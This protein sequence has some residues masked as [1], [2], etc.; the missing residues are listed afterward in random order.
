MRIHTPLLALC[1]A[2][3]LPACT[4]SSSPSTPEAPTDISITTGAAPALIAVR[5]ES[6]GAWRRLVADSDG[7]F[8]ATVSGP[9]R[10]VVVCETPGVPRSISATEYARTSEDEPAIQHL[11]HDAPPYRLHGRMLSP[12]TV[13]FGRVS[14]SD[15]TDIAGFSLPASPGAF[16]LVMHQRSGPREP[17]QIAIRRDVEISG[18]TDLGLIDLRSEHVDTMT[19]Q[20]LETSSIQPNE[21][22][23]SSTLLHTGTT[24]A[25]LDEQPGWRPMLAPDAVLLPT[26]RQIVTL[27]A[28]EDP[29]DAALPSHR[30]AVSHAIREGLTTPFL[31]PDPVGP[32]AF[33]PSDNRLDATWSELPEHDE[34]WL[35]RAGFEFARGTI[36]THELALSR[37]FIDATRAVSAT[38]DFSRVPGFDPAWA[39][40]PGALQYFGLTASLGAWQEGA[41]SSVWEQL[42]PPV[43]AASEA[44]TAGAELGARDLAAAFDARMR[45]LRPTLEAP[46]P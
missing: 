1:T 6:S 19:P 23:G 2:A 22:P 25:T 26:D 24:I 40:D 41:T 7:L 44:P 30:R 34:L 38:L 39:I 4:T 16:D 46:A 9:Y 21:W 42:P 3:G 27:D 33:A 5:E 31:L 29:G 18:N 14:T 15:T 13:S 32:V 37:A 35:S 45:A 28:T 20:A 8:R 11:C 10:A 43:A 36:W 12:A 17:G